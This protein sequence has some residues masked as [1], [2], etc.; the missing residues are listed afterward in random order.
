MC[1][2]TNDFIY[3]D[4][5]WRLCAWLLMSWCL[6]NDKIGENCVNWQLCLQSQAVTRDIMIKRTSSFKDRFKM[7]SASKSVEGKKPSDSEFR[8]ST[9]RR[10]LRRV[11]RAVEWVMVDSLEP[12][13]IWS[14]FRS[15]SSPLM[16]PRQDLV[17][18]QSLSALPAQP[19]PAKDHS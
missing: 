14:M 1:I 4:L 10:S 18:T 15:V 16:S 19:S 8:S 6:Q 3:F 9:L 12:E 7:V 2:Q 11:R 5:L 13:L 17:K